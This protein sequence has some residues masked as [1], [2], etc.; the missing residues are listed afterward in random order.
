[1]S[2]YG[3]NFIYKGKSSEIYGLLCASTQ[4]SGEIL[5]SAGS[6]ITILEEYINRR[7]TPYFY[8]VSFSEKLQFDVSFYSET[9]IPRQKVSEIEKWLFGLL[10][11]KQ[12]QVIQE[13]MEGIYY[14]CLFTN[15]TVASVGNEVVGF[16]ATCVCDAPWAWGEE[17]TYTKTNAT[18]VISILNRSDNAR[19]TKPTITLTFTSNQEEVSIVN[20]SDT[21][22]TAMIFE[23]VV[24]GEIIEINCDLKTISSNKELIVERFNGKYMYLIPDINTITITGTVGTFEVTYTPAKKVGS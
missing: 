12:F 2:F 3:K 21:E 15:P 7:E 11:Y 1:M 4:G 17:I 6:N 8:G 22:S 9:Q 20:T 23:E 5:S 19:Y 10:E 18:G 13:D 14:N 16:H 24:I